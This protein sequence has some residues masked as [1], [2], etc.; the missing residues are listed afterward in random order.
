MPVV[1]RKKPFRTGRS[2]VVTFPPS[3]TSLKSDRLIVAFDRV[4][5]VAP[6]D[7]TA[8]E[9]EADVKNLVAVLKRELSH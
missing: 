7:I 4:A 1:K 2:M 8:D 6:Q 9:L 3:W 5:I